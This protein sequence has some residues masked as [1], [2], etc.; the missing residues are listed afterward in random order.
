M[1]I[2]RTS[3]PDYKENNISKVTDNEKAIDDFAICFE[4]KFSNTY[5][6]VQH[7][8]P[9]R[10]FVLL[11]LFLHAFFNFLQYQAYAWRLRLYTLLRILSADAYHHTLDF[12]YSVTIKI[13]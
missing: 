6:N 8:F 9:L 10:I 11:V 3:E 5:N 1:D 13:L 7:I 4:N 2:I 12:V